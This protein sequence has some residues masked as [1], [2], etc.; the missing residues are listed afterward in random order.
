MLIFLLSITVIVLTFQTTSHF[1]TTLVEIMFI[2]SDE[3]EI[4]S[5]L[6]ALVRHLRN[7][8]WVINPTKIQRPT[9]SVK[10]LKHHLKGKRQVAASCMTNQQKEAQCWVGFFGFWRHHIFEYL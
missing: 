1:S 7:K 6:D 9:S 3:Q 5:S 10:F 8:E 4:T 2:A